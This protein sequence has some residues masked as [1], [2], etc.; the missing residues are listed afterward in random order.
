MR[1][2]VIS[3]SGASP[4]AN[5]SILF[6][7]LLTVAA[8]SSNSGGT[9]AGAG[10]TTGSSSSSG[11]GGPVCGAPTC[12]CSESLTVAPN[13]AWCEAETVP[14]DC[15]IVSVADHE[16]VCGVALP[17]PTTTLSRSANV[18]EFA[19]SGPPD[20]SCFAPANYPK[21]GT[22]QMVTVSGVAKIFAHGCAST[23]LDIE[24]HTVTR[25]NDSH[26]GEVGA[27]IG[28]AVTTPADCK[29]TSTLITNDMNCGTIYEC[30]Y[31]YP[32]VPS[33]TELVILTQGSA[34]APLYEYNNYI[35]TSQVTNGVWN[36]DVRALATD[37]YSA[38]AVASE[39]GGP[40]TPGNGAIAGEAHDCGNVRLIGAT[41][42]V[43]VEA[44]LLTYFTDD[45]S[46]PL[47]DSTATS[48]TALGL[49][50][51]LDVAPGP[52]EVAALG[53]VDG[54]VTTIGWYQAQVYPNSVTA[55]TFQGPRPFQIK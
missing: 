40:I 9:G 43:N 32:N 37:D 51:A 46:N 26:N 31:S 35:P 50:A 21:A 44:K 30:N 23:G 6:G 28:T 20:L 15:N 38:I 11:S 4:L 19:G 16:E 39:L 29:T 1:T 5:S 33:E 53:L 42:N 3:R 12:T 25:S 8:C 48:T 13:S 34:W 17:S 27:L 45:E 54:K 7:A 49:Y 55:I 14:I 41:V 47:P 24:F 22:S 2:L 10:T 36:H 52:V 18:K